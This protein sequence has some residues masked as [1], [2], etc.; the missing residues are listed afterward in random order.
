MSNPVA[1]HLPDKLYDRIRATAE[2]HNRSLES[3]MVDSLALIFDTTSHISPENLEEATD[4]ELW[5]IVQRP[6]AFPVDIR[7]REL[8]A[9]SKLGQLSPAQQ[10]ELDRLADHFDEYI[11]LRSRALV[12][13][14]QRGHDVEQ[15]LKAG[16]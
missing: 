7:L 15:R 4:E 1:L 3:V 10:E 14:K 12:V 13:L 16:G 6:L 8:T 5:A 9:L 11:L 2:R